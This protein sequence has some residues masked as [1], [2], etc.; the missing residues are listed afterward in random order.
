MLGAACL[1]GLTTSGLVIGVGLASG[2]RS[3]QVD[4]AECVA[5]VCVIVPYVVMHVHLRVNK[6]L[7]AEDKKLWHRQLTAGQWAFVAPFFYLL[8]KSRRLT[9]PKEHPE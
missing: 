4:A 6:R 3:T 7:T 8:R 1:F 2:S 9:D 5:T